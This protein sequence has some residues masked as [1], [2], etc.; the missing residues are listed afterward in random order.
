MATVA[1]EP[2]SRFTHAELAEIFNA[3]YEG[4][5]TPFTLDEDTFRFMSRIW[6]DDL[7]ASRVAI[8]DGEPAG[9]CKLGI[10]GDRGWIA[11]IGISTAH[12]GQG[13]GE[14]LM[15]GVLDVARD[16]GLREVWLEVLVQNEPAIRLYEK[17]GFEHVRDLEVWTLDARSG[18]RPERPT[19]PARAGAGADPARTAGAG[20]VAAC[21]RIGREP[22]RGRGPRE[23][24][25]RRR[26]PQQGRPDIVVARRRT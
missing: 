19:R 10:R 5:Y 12:R 2:A 8:V 9:I 4:Y 15:R 18:R 16:R 1:L 23:R 6:D 20:A 25:R 14:E 3:G 22:R 21:R 11:G 24:A 7:D 26:L 17:L 13:V